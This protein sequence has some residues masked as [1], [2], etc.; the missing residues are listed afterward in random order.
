MYKS[1]IVDELGHVVFWCDELSE[2][3]ITNILDS[4]P[5]MTIKCVEME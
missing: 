3:Q 2:E 5:E 1:A 4:S